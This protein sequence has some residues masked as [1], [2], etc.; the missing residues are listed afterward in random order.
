MSIHLN[1]IFKQRI[2]H[3]KLL[4]KVNIIYKIHINLLKITLHKFKTNQ[5]FPILNIF[6]K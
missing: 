2:N 1:W 3:H 4:I 5:G 6:W